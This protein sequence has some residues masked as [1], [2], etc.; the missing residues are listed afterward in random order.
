MK[1]Y[2]M[3]PTMAYG[4]AIG[5]EVTAIYDILT[6]MGYETCV[7]AVNIDYKLKRDI[8]RPVDEYVDDPE[9]VLIY[10][11]S[12]GNPLNDRLKSFKAKKIIIYHN[13]TPGHF[14][15]DYDPKL[16]KL[17]NDGVKSVR[18]LAKFPD[19]CISVST[20]N[21]NDLI[22]Y[23]YKCP[24]EVVP[25]IIDFDALDIQTSEEIERRY[26][27]DGIKNIVFIGRIAPNKKQEDLIKAF[28]M[29]RS[30]ISA[31]ARLFLVGGYLKEDKYYRKLRAY[32]RE[33]DLE[34]SVIFTGHVP[35][36]E[37][38][39]YYK[40]ADA[41]V[42]LSEHEGFC[43]PL[44]E[45]MYFGVPII[46]YDCCAT[47]ETLGDGGILLKDKEPQTVAEALDLVLNNEDVRRTVIEHGKLRLKY[48]RR[49]NVIKMFREVLD[50]YI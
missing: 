34:D 4:D 35:S 16:E 24:H 11:L 23:G 29:Y 22:S 19:V 32:V 18:S 44:V 12:I 25:V 38:L 2:Q 36:E 43:V 30:Y 47:A 10:H 27:S 5:N 37:M 45:A 3:L 20:F 39:A 14:F 42:C 50:R 48:F 1:I 49:E 21:K 31:D 7:Y 9:N 40:I 26:S 41:F 13:V 17:C 15:H 33:L 6:D 8:T 46:V 28:Y